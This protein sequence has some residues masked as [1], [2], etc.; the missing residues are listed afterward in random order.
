MK[1]RLFMDDLRFTVE[2]GMFEAVEQSRFVSPQECLTVI[3]GLL[4]II[5]TLT[6]EPE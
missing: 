2:N 5:G 3:E 4:A 6:K 1:P